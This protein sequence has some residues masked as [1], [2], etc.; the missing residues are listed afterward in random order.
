MAHAKKQIAVD[1]SC[2]SSDSEEYQRNS[3]QLYSRRYTSDSDSST[4]S[5]HSINRKSKPCHNGITCYNV[6]C[7]FDHLDGWN[8]CKYGIRCKNYYCIANHPFKRRAKCRDGN[9]CKI[10]DCKFLHPNTRSEQCPSGTMCKKWNC[11]NLH[12]Y[13]RLGLCNNKENC[14]NLNCL[15]LHPS[16][17][18]SICNQPDT[19]SNINCTLLHGSNRNLCEDKYSSKIDLPNRIINRHENA[20]TIKTAM[21]T[22]SH[23]PP[24][25]V[26]LFCIFIFLFSF[27]NMYYFN[28]VSMFSLIIYFI[29]FSIVFFLY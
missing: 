10:S 20:T 29:F 19:C 27:F 23:N 11:Q 7:E 28:L 2:S 22:I 15:F 16:E 3:P 24:Q 1:E 18:P 25:F 8:P 21:T 12:P 4:N 5:T 17:R 26:A 6:N 14:T 13:S 9:H